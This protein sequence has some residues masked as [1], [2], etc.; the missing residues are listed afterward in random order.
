MPGTFEEFQGLKYTGGDAWDSLRAY[1]RGV[2][3]NHLSVLTGLEHYRAMMKN[4]RGNLVGLTTS[5][6]IEIKGASY[7]YIDRTIGNEGA[8]MSRKGV[9]WEDAREALM[10]PIFTEQGAGTEYGQSVRYYGRNCM[11]TVDPNTG[12]LIQTNPIKRR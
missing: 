8:E 3:S 2:K 6:G 1:V 5:D 4:V 7:H 9:A 10:N 12:V 11:V